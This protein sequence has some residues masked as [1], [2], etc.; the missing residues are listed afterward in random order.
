MT[1]ITT[2]ATDTRKFGEKL[3]QK[4]LPGTVVCLRGDLGAGKT[5]LIQ[6][7]ARGLG[8]K[9][10]INSPTFII[11]RHYD[12]F[13]HLDLYRLTCLEEALVVGIEEILNEKSGIILIEW[14]EKIEKILPKKRWEISLETISENKRRIKYETLS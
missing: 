14:P 7:I 9:N 4:F 8:I 12:N 3:S 5:T 6:G 13:W 2:S 11:V 1:I 10:R